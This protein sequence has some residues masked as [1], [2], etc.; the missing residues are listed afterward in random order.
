MLILFSLSWFKVHGQ[1]KTFIFSNLTEED[2][3]SYNVVNCFLKDS[4]G[5][6]WVGTYNG[7]SR[8][9]GS[10]F[11]N[12]KIRKGS[13]SLI[14]EVIHSLC[15][16]RNGNIWGGTDNGVF[17]YVLKEDRFIN[18]EISS[19][20]KAATF[21]EIIC[22]NKGDIWAAGGWS[23]F[24][25]N[26]QENKFKETVKLAETSNAFNYFRIVKNGFL[27]DPSGNG[28]WMATT[29]GLIYYD[30]NTQSLNDS[31]TNPLDSL[32]KVRV[33][34]GLALASSDNIWFF[35]NNQMKAVL[36]T[37]SNRKILR[38]VAFKN[39]LSNSTVNTLFED[40]NNRLWL[41]TWN[42]DL[43]VIDLKKNNSV[44]RL[45]NKPFDKSSVAS[46]L[47]WAAYQDEDNTIWLG[48]IAGISRCNPERNI[49]TE[50]GLHETIPELKDA[51]LNYML[52]DPEDKTLWLTTSSE[53]LINY[54]PVNKQHT[55]FDIKKAL[56][57]KKGI[58]PGA[59][60]P[61][62]FY[63]GYV[64]IPTYTGA[65]QLKKGS[66]KIVP[67]D[68]LPPSHPDFKC[69]EVLFSGD[70]AAYF[71]NGR[72]LLYW[73]RL[74]GYS[75]II[76]FAPDPS[77]PTGRTIISSIMQAKDKKIWMTSAVTHIAYLGIDRKLV[78]IKVDK[79]NIN[80]SGAVSSV[81]EDSNGNIWIV[82]K[83]M[84]LYRYTPSTKEFRFWN[85]P[86]GLP[87]N[88]IQKSL[89]DREDRVWS[90][91]Y[92]KLSIYI[93]ETDKFYNFKIPYSESNYAY[94]NFMAR[95]SNGNLLANIYNEVFEF[96]PDRL[97]QKPQLKKPQISQVSVSGKD[98][99]LF[100]GEKIILKPDENTIRFHFG[101]IINREI[102]PHD[103]EY[104]LEGA[105]KKWTA[106]GNNH[107]ALYNNLQ[108]GDYTFM[109][110]AKG[111]NNTWKTEDAVLAFT[112]QTPFYKT[113]WFLISIAIL[114][115]GILFFIYRY[116]LTQKE[117]LMMLENK[118]QSLEK[119]KAMVMY[120]NLKQQLNPHFLFNSLTSLNSLIVAE[121]KEASEFLDSLSKT[122]RYILKSRDN[123]TVPLIDEIRFA[124]N[125]VKLQK[126][127][128]E[129]GFD[130]N[131]N[132]P[133]EYYHRKIVPVT[134]Q[135]LVENAI[136]HNILDEDS[137]L[138]VNMFVEND[139]L[140]VENNLQKKKFVE[141]SNRQGLSNMQSLYN[142]LSNRPVEIIETVETF[143][144]KL[145]L[146]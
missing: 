69:A 50:Y 76:G 115:S 98:V 10:N 92:N 82:N 1:D 4:R 137:P 68:L 140:V 2:G 103:I 55:V 34:S 40:R 108:P 6:L 36:F 90:I 48:T 130:V 28:F 128:F 95:M 58:M 23:L 39:H 73:N 84:G 27:E 141:T 22:D 75:E 63:N 33:V 32:F 131:I 52:E 44:T 99:N 85:E 80:G 49:Y 74:T 139:Y 105:E 41:S 9:D 51:S 56:P 125:Y 96:Y 119:E 143:K 124:E 21:T 77:I 8:Y 106:A 132:I 89:T 25:L 114:V 53:L 86:D 26:K 81:D 121:P 87:G 104:M 107:E 134:L 88:R 101:S 11:Y 59:I 135:N 79:E 123:E 142:Y 54:N 78:R 18:Y 62:R 38:E 17:C 37:P 100:A 127:R 35:D 45:L 43:L 7:F 113:K 116:R 145:P 146:L 102:F 64:I 13:N 71:N 109:V 31:R 91:I 24:K 111:N 83:G 60:N 117:K 133:E 93:P 118:A 29:S 65:W 120:E 20:N 67:F 122:Y 61:I 57:D 129:K 136:K 94:V 42:Y 110:R 5:I 30:K 144:I 126:T 138:V 46:S 72:E 15:E 14:S 12:Y 66:N 16:D 97:V 19:L 3:L 70:T 112:I 47:F